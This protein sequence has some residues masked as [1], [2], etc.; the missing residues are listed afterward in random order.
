MSLNA[1]LWK[2]PLFYVLKLVLKLDLTLVLL[3]LITCRESLT[4]VHRKRLLYC[5]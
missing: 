1:F 3:L 2:W 4:N 5:I